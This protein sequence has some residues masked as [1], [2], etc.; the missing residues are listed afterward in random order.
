MLVWAAP[1]KS[2]PP[3]V[4]NEIYCHFIDNEGNVI[5][6]FDGQFCAFL[7]DG[8]Y[9]AGSP[10]GIT[11][12]KPNGTIKWHRKMNVHHQLNLNL[13]GDKLLVLSTTV[14]KFEGK[15]AR[16]DKLIVLGLD[17]KKQMSYDFYE[18]RE[19]FMK[20]APREP[21]N[22]LA[23]LKF[24]DPALPTEVEWEFSHANSFYEIP[25]NSAAAKN[26]AFAKGNFIVNGLGRHTVAVL[27]KK[28]KK[29]LWSQSMYG[30]FKHDV[31]MQE[32]GKILLYS[33]EN[34]D[35]KTGKNYSAIHELDPIT[36]ET[37]VLYKADPP[38]A[39]N[40]PWLGGVQRLSNQHLLISDV[41]NGG[42][43]LEI[44]GAGKVVWSMNYPFLDS[45]NGKPAEIQQAKR[46]DFSSFLKNHRGL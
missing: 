45:R 15:T 40:S 36:G 20:L 14:N 30:H 39:F 26:P 28:L 1:G 17:G 46:R 34:A 25:D 22:I 37:S 41:T 10:S 29:V 4:Y 2:L 9:A 27:D 8:S 19:E 35:P 6:K 24:R 7:P 5:K 16:F 38:E 13:A 44:D 31:Q 18:H 33:N 23:K 42:R 32:S 11:F 12:Y 3:G 21:G 43:V